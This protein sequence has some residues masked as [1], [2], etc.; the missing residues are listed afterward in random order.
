PCTGL[1]GSAASSGALFAAFR[2]ALVLPVS[3]RRIATTASHLEREVLGLRC[4]LQDQLCAAT[5]GILDLRFFE[6]D[7]QIDPI[8]APPSLVRDLCAGLLL[9][10]TRVR[11]VS[12]EILNI[13][14]DGRAR[15][16][17]ADL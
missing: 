2:H 4:G 15:D 9:V 7:F 12:G 11:R 1:G 10:D 3:A 16:L 6:D 17:P 8:A 5:G 14:N 13:A